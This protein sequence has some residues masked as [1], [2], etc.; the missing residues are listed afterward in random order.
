LVQTLQ[1]PQGRQLASVI[2]FEIMPL[3]KKNNSLGAHQVGEGVIF[4]E[5]RMALQE[6]K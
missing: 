4:T 5:A 6:D 2:I 1:L 3:T